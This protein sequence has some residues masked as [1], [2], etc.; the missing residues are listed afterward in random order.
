[1]AM[2]KFSTYLSQRSCLL[3]IHLHITLFSIKVA[4]YSPPA[5]Q[6][7]HSPGFLFYPWS[8]RVIISISVSVCCFSSRKLTCDWACECIHLCWLIKTFRMMSIQTWCTLGLHHW[9]NKISPFINQ[10]NCHFWH[11]PR[12]ALNLFNLTPCR[13]WKYGLISELESFPI[14]TTTITIILLPHN[15]GVPEDVLIL[16]AIFLVLIIKD[17]TTDVD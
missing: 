2:S 15:Y 14:I 7:P 12:I 8:W 13:K 5:A 6:T 1:M 16:H 4:Q 10:E 17:R 3:F 11:W 9:N